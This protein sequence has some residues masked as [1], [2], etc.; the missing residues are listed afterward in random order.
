MKTFDQQRHADPTT[1]E[2]L[3]HKPCTVSLQI[4]GSNERHCNGLLATLKMMMIMAMTM[5]V[6][7]SG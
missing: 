1:T 4:R 6:V 7:S 5:I 3:I 2:Y